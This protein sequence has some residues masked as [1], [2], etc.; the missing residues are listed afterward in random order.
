MYK[1]SSPEKVEIKPGEPDDICI[2][3][4]SK[5][6]SEIPK[7]EE[8]ESQEEEEHIRNMYH[9]NGIDTLPLAE[10][11]DEDDYPE[12]YQDHVSVKKRKE[13]AR[14]GLTLLE[15]IMSGEG[16]MNE[17]KFLELS[18]VFRDIHQN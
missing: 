16:K 5:Y 18:N 10:E 3:L 7:S 6:C 8:L 1:I 15:E 4:E 12:E 13:C 17:G 9:I 2:H 11:Y 14:K